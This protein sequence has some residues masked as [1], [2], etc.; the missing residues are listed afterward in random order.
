MI[1]SRVSFSS[2]CL[3]SISDVSKNQGNF[4][5]PPPGKINLRR[6]RGTHSPATATERGTQGKG[7]GNLATR[8]G[9]RQ[10][11]PRRRHGPNPTTLATQTG[12]APMLFLRFRRK[13]PQTLPT[14]AVLTAS[15]HTSHCCAGSRMVRGRI[16]YSEVGW[17]S[18]GVMVGSRGPK[19]AAT[20]DP[21]IILAA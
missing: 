2:L 8:P 16:W 3:Q 11:Q 15:S 6:H 7:R 9:V 18:Q 13:V 10:P 12:T 14:G 20:W 19:L 4:Y 21:T 17:I 5:R 1:A